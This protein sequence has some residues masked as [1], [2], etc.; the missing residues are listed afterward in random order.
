MDAGRAK[1]IALHRERHFRSSRGPH[2]CIM[3]IKP[4]P[5]NNIQYSNLSAQAMESGYGYI[6]QAVNIAASTSG[7]TSPH[8]HGLRLPSHKSCSTVSPLLRQLQHSLSMTH[9]C[10]TIHQRRLRVNFSKVSHCL[11]EFGRKH[12][13]KLTSIYCVTHGQ[14]SS[15]HRELVTSVIQNG[16]SSSTPVKHMSYRMHE[17]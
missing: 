8:H 9:R 13:S 6:Y 3:T 5:P 17:S 14:F 15:P 10:P 12:T 1:F 2:T 4:W 7:G 16:T 11:R